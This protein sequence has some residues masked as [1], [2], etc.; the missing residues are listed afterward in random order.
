MALQSPVHD[1]SF[2]MWAPPYFNSDQMSIP[3]F[4]MA[5]VPNDSLT[6]TTSIVPF[7]TWSSTLGRSLRRL[8]QLVCTGRHVHGEWEARSSS[9]GLNLHSQY[10]VTSGG[11]MGDIIFNGGKYGIQVG[12]QQF[13]VRNLI[14]N[15]AATGFTF[16]AIIDAV[17]TNTPIFLRS[18]VASKGQLAGFLVLN[19][20][21]L[22]NVPTAVGVVGGTTVLAGG[23]TTIASW[24]QGNVYSG[25]SG[26]KNFTQ[27]NIV[28][29]NKPSVL[30]DSAGRIFG[31]THPQYAN[32][33][34][35]Q[36]VTVKNQG[37][38]GD[39]HTDDTTTIQNILNEYAGCKII[40]FDAG[41]YYVTNT[42][43]MPAGA[44]IVGEA[45]KLVMFWPGLAQSH[46]FGL[47][48]IK[49]R[50]KPQMTVGFGLALA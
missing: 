29:A 23:T 48:K 12:N 5:G 18:S 21:K 47:Q 50:P 13:T 37:V 39:G 35:S 19:N 46:G 17:V 26:S 16:Q 3:I 14:V 27:G 15:N 33:A 31:K 7:T 2:S 24:G 30:L 38:K 42:I 32:Y 41:T 11:F 4:P 22:I 25:T 20:I 49:A 40:F 43:T 34:M 10:A 36:F 28:S 8:W 9:S 44:Q 1:P 45:F 6:K